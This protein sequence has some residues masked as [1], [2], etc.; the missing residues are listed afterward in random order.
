MKCA[1]GSLFGCITVFLYLPCNV[2]ENPKTPSYINGETVPTSQPSASLPL[3]QRSI[4]SSIFRMGFPSMIGFLTLNVYTLVDLFWLGKLGEQHVAAITLFEGIYFLFFAV[5]EMVDMGALAVIS[6]RFGEEDYRLT[7]A[8]IKNGFLLKIISACIF[9]FLGFLFLKP[10]LVLIG[11]EDEVLELAIRYGRIMLIALMFRFGLES[12]YSIFRSIEAPLTAMYIMISGMVLNIILD[13][14][15]IFGWGFLPPLGILGAAIASVL[16]FACTTVIGLWLLSSGRLSIR[17]KL[18]NGIPVQWKSMLH[19]LKIGWP[20]AV[21][22]SS[23][24]FA[25]FIVI[26]II[27]DLGTRVIAIYGMGLRLL[28]VG[29]LCMDGLGRGI[30]PLIGNIL[31]IG[32][33]KR[34]WRTAW[35]AQ[36]I[37]LVIISS[38]AICIF[39]FAEPITRAFFQ[40]EVMV[41][42]GVQ[43][44][45]IISLSLPLIGL[46][47]IIE[48]IFRG[49]GDNLPPM[50][51]AV[52]SLWGLH[53]PAIILMTRKFEFDQN[54]IWWIWVIS[55]FLEVSVIFYWYLKGNWAKKEV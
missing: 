24:S 52:V 3:L 39:S 54:A 40:D 2:P 20:V 4:A 23:F 32:L 8:A 16:S 41:V 44:L 15:L 21:I 49:A 43:M 14:M 25:E 1:L 42:M 31:G 53:V 28:M 34:A 30:S 22:F 5:N 55:S 46:Y 37:G 10:L 7:N 47:I 38:F 33:Q 48:S 51:I 13:P 26:T 36:F 50:I 35:Q 12:I 17:I 6:R 19:M 18:G 9:G 11:A 29:I 45:C 27:A